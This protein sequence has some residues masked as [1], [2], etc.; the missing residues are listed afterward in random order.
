MPKCKNDPS[1]SYTGNEPSPKGL[2]YCAHAMK[3]GQTKKGLD[4]KL[5]TVIATKN[6]TKRW[7]KK[8]SRKKYS[9]SKTSKKSVRKNKL[10]KSFIPKNKLTQKNKIYYVHDNGSRPFKVIINNRAIHIYKF[11]YES[12]KYDTDIIKITKYSGYWYGYDSSGYRQHGNSILIKISDNEYIFV[13]WEIYS[14]KTNNPIIDYISP[15]GNSDVPY[16]IAYNDSYVY[17]MLDKRYVSIDELDIDINV[18]NALNIYDSY[19][20]LSIKPSGKKFMELR[21]ISKRL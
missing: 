13:G 7:I 20:S 17:F 19:Y 2:G 4:G 1:K 10:S 16:P 14:F 3:I 6:N 8:S 12:E 11:S 5:W 15:L 21:M 18:P 9:G